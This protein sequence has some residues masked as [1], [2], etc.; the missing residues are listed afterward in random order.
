MVLADFIPAVVGNAM[1]VFGRDQ[2]N[3]GG[4]NWG[5]ATAMLLFL[6]GAVGALFFFT[7]KEF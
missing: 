7:W 3:R 1:Q 6:V 4:L 2:A 5:T